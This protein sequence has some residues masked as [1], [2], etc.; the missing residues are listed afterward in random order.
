MSDHHRR[1]LSQEP[2]AVSIIRPQGRYRGEAPTGSSSYPV[3]IGLRERV[4]LGGEHPS[5]ISI[6]RCYVWRLVPIWTF[7][8]PTAGTRA[9]RRPRLALSRGRRSGR[10]GDQRTIIPLAARIIFPHC[11]KGRSGLGPTSAS[12]AALMTWCGIV[13]VGW[14][15]DGV[16]RRA[17]L[18]NAPPRP[19]TVVSS[20]KCGM[21]RIPGIP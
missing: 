16:H 20:E 6:C 11:S 14:S 13:G 4:A 9:R 18:W 15:G 5:W 7:W 1:D 21:S 17:V 19:Y 12:P 3:M 8:S 10:D 2:G